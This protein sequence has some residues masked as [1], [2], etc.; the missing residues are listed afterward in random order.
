MG[1]K[2]MFTA[3]KKTE[4]EKNVEELQ[5]V[6]SIA[7]EYAQKLSRLNEG[8]RLVEIE[9]EVDEKDKATQARKTKLENA[10]SQIQH[11]LESLNDRKNQ[12]QSSIQELQALERQQLIQETAHKDSQAFTKQYRAKALQSE[13][14]RL[15]R[16]IDSRAGQASSV[17]PQSLQKLAG[18]KHLD[19]KDLAHQEFLVPF[20]QAN[21]QAKKEAEKELKEVMEAIHKFLG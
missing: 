1:L 21:E 20:E 4:L 3:K 10:V 17:Q 9:L 5:V 2:D 16:E 7:N 19:R 11:E 6:T 18:V 15:S 13:L 12:L 8:L 14:S